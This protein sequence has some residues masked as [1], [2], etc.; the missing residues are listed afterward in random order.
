MEKII[1]PQEVVKLAFTDG[2]YLSPEVI[3]EA[4]ID[5]VVERWILPVVGAS[6]I[7]AVATG[8]YAAFAEGYLKP[9]LAAYVRLEVQP[10]LNVATSQMGLTIPTTTHRKVADEA[11]RRELMV[12]LK[13]RAEA[14]SRRMSRYL[15]DKADEMP[16]YIPSENV[17]KRSSCYGGF[18]QIH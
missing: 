8:A 14:L 5:A 2:E 3:A 12:A 18:V 17:L 15:D 11:L 16:E 9:T 7:K 10:R 4:D 6:L 1:T 13:R